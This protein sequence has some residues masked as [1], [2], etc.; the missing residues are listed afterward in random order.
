MAAA[1]I[2]SNLQAQSESSSERQKQKHVPSASTVPKLDGHSATTNGLESIDS[3][4]LKD[5]QRSLRNANKK[6]N[7]TTKV[8]AIIAENPGKSLD[9]LVA[10]KK[11]NA[12]QKAQAEKKP[13]LQASVAQI[14]EQIAHYKEFATQYEQR[15][16]SQK[17]ELEK[18]HQEE[19]SAVREKAIFEA[20]EAGQKDLRLR[21][22]TLSKFLCAAATMRRSGDETSS[23]T[24]AFEGVLYQVYAGSHD[25][26]TSMLKVID[27]VDELVV[28]VEGETL[29]VTYGKV[30]QTSEE[31]TPTTEEVTADVA[32]ASDSALVN[33][34]YTELQESTYST[35]AA[36]ANEPEPAGTPSEQIAPPAQ[37]MVSDAANAVAEAN[38]DATAGSLTSSAVTESWVEVPRDPAETDTGLEATPAAVNADARNSPAAEATTPNEEDGSAPKAQQGDAAEGTGHHQ[39]QHS[40]R[41]RGRGGRGRGDGSRGRGRGEFRGRGRG[42][43]GGRGRGG[44]NGSPAAAPTG[45]Q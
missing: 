1:T 22:L 29:D 7:A 16:A 41:G 4:Y 27:G 44:P 31:Q 43:R 26:V 37:T 17:A 33:A 24:R 8:D 13:A 18:A 9:E 40:V 6:L 15:L 32:P 5:L 3:P 42:G 12:D 14:E 23:V 38:W 21:L 19:L 30:K 10:E 25:A 11:I 34:G 36:A 45:G 2:N 20:S 28:S 39:R 35:S